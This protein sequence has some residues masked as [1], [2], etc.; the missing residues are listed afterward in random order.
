MALIESKL[1]RVGTTI[2]T[3]MSALA[4]E[5]NALNLSQGFP[6][7][8]APPA[9]D[10]SRFSFTPSAGTYFQL[11]DYSAITESLDTRLAE[12]WTRQLGIAAIPVSV[13]YQSPP[14]QC[15]LRFCFA[16]NDEVLLEAA[17]ILCTI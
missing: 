9:L 7:F 6:D 17:N 5:C 14:Q 12:D 1:P 2:F 15:Y 4:A 3:R 11:L 16:K 13:F 10:N 8:D